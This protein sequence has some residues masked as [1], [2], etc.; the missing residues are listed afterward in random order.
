[1]AT[2]AVLAAAL[3]TGPAVKYSIGVGS[4]LAAQAAQKASNNYPFG[5][6]AL[7][8]AHADTGLVGFYVVSH[9]EKIGTLV[10]AA[11]AAFRE[12]AKGGIN[13]EQ[14]NRA[15]LVRFFLFVS[16]PLPDRIACRITS[17]TIRISRRALL[18]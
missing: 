16:Q 11:V 10:K 8:A 7:S 15:K 1:M 12:I 18:F 13:D 2:Q 9:G 3:G 5:I 4:G 14:L 17:R 6:S